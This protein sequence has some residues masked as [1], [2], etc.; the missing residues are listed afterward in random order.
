M[1]ILDDRARGVLYASALLFLAAPAA[2]QTVSSTLKGTV[3][4]TSGAVVVNAVCRLANP[5]INSSSMV[6]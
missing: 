1:G 5:D 2:A 3:R 4:D 6:A